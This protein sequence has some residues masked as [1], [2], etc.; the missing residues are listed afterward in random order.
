MRLEFSC[1]VAS[2]FVVCFTGAAS[3]ST[4][5]TVTSASDDDTADT[6]CTLREAIVAANARGSY[7]GCTAVGTGDPTTIGFALPGSGVR[8]IGVGSRLLPILVPVILDATTQPGADCAQWPP[9]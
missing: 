6:L 7:H 3:A 8:H 1:L 4:R 9:A 2:I 5:L